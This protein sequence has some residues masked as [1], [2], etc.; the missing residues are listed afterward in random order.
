MRTFSKQGALRRRS[1]GG[2]GICCVTTR[3]YGRDTRREAEHGAFFDVTFIVS[4]VFFGVT[5]G[6]HGEENA[7]NAHGGF[8]DVRDKFLLGRFVE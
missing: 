1:F 8:D 4:H 7:V 2:S 5:G 3:I 6:E